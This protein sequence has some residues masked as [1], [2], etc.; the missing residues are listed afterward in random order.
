M[1]G[2]AEVKK[3]FGES[4]FLLRM[5]LAELKLLPQSR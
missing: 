3:G 1:R 4:V 2:F 5:R